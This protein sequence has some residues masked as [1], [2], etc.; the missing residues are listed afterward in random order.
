MQPADTVAFKK[1]NT[2]VRAPQRARAGAAKQSFPGSGRRVERQFSSG[3]P[4]A[5]RTN[6]RTDGLWDGPR[7][8]LPHFLP[9]APGL[10][11]SLGGGGGDRPG[12]PATR[13]SPRG[14]PRV[15][16]TAAPSRG[17][18][19]SGPAVPAG[20]SCCGQWLRHERGLKMARRETVAAHK[21]GAPPLP[22]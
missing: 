22:R 21:E 1:T 8:A 20:S 12:G 15:R 16:L 18:S 14:L 11:P 17:T 13:P 2:R 5:A 4:R 10:P 19:P 6:G 3:R 7:A 9:A